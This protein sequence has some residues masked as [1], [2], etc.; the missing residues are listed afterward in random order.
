MAPWYRLRPSRNSTR[1]SATGSG[2]RRRLPETA[3]A[4]FARTLLAC[5]LP[6]TTK[7]NRSSHERRREL[8][9]QRQSQRQLESIGGGATATL[10]NTGCA[11]T[12]EG[13]P[14]WTPLTAGPPSGRAF[15]VRRMTEDENPTETIE[16][17]DSPAKQA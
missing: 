16:E 11:Q 12:H 1:S 8:Q 13:L 14:T 17:A 15:S 2:C 7:D 5:A 6:T 4:T 3:R 10:N 9:S